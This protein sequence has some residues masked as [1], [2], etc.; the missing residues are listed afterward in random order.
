MAISQQLGY[1]L[2]LCATVVPERNPA[3]GANGKE[4]MAYRR[5]DQCTTERR[6]RA[7]IADP[8]G[9]TVRPSLLHYPSWLSCWGKP[10]EF[11]RPVEHHVQLRR[12]RFLLAGLNH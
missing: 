12:R 1:A 4:Q 8:C 5:P 10:A 9:Q 2:S 3:A 6:T 11:V 7:T